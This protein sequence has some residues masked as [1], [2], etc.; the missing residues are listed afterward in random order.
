MHDLLTQFHFLR[1]W[2]LLA[3][4]AALPLLWLSATKTRLG[5]WS[6]VIDPRWLPFMLEPGTHRRRRQW[7]W[8][9]AT[10]IAAV[11]LAGPS[12]QQLPQPLHKNQ[13][14]LVILLDLSP[15]MAATDIKPNRITS[16]RYKLQDIL[17]QRTEG[18]TA[19]VVYSGSAHIVTP[20]TDDTATIASQVDVLAPELISKRGS[21]TEAAIAMAVEMLSS[22][23]HHAGDILLITDGVA[24]AAEKNIRK[25]LRNSTV[26]LSVLGVGTDSGAPIALPGGGFAKDQNGNIV[27]P[28]LKRKSLIELAQRNR[29]QY[30]DLTP[31]NRDLR[32]L[33]NVFN[34]N[35]VSQ[36]TQLDRTFDHWHDQGYWLV[37]LLLPL[38]IAGFRKGLV[39]CL[40]LSPLAGTL[41][42]EPVQAAENKPQ[43]IADHLPEFLQNKDQQGQRAFQ[44]KQFEKASERFKD[45]QWKGSAAYRNG[46]FETAL[47]QF[48]KDDSATGLYNQGNAL[49]Q[50]GE[51]DKAIEA[52]EK[53]LQKDPTRE[54]AAANKKLLEALKKQQQQNQSDEQQKNENSQDSQQQSSQ[55]NSPQNSQQG[56][57]QNAEQNDSEQ[58]SRE[59]TNSP[60]QNDSPERNNSPEHN[61]SPERNNSPE[62]SDSP[63]QQSKQQDKQNA[64]SAQK[65]SDQENPDQKRSE[66]QNRK[67]SDK[68]KSQDEQQPTAEPQITPSD[69]TA[70][71]EAE[72]ALEQYLRKVPDRPG[73][74]LKEKFRRQQQR[75]RERQ[76]QPERW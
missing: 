67:P 43:T 41:M 6:K 76:E 75:Q 12:W 46:D 22:G 2:W 64:D 35:H 38:V 14:A 27:I 42:V 37:L 69:K 40:L 4:V 30:S 1:P 13:N 36:S 33:A 71:E 63:E 34:A 15:S 32:I 18:Q 72:Q 55:Q 66:Q 53:A 21:N 59:Q 23:G 17:Q 24:N 19:L 29:G 44:N 54:D 62:H 16:A 57:S 11:A 9:L 50:L 31:D 3:I 39:A 28:G 56:D 8:L 25:Q 60:E 52:Y 74:F 48:Q 68:E 10:G 49:A 45:S 65:D 5:S 20:L 73:A 61:D 70:R 58:N 7:P 51:L 26:R 47:Q